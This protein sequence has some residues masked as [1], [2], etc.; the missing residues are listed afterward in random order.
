VLSIVI[1]AALTFAVVVTEPAFIVMPLMA[2]VP[3]LV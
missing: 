3:D 1:W 2:I